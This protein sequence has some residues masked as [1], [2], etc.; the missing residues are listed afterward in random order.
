MMGVPYGDL[1]LK[2][3]TLASWS[4]L[5]V[6]GPRRVQGGFGSAMDTAGLR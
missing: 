3:L 6:T 5:L 4:T 2:L 1:A